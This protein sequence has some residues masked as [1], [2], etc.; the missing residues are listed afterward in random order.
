MLTCAIA[1]AFMLQASVH[2]FVLYHATGIF[3]GSLAVS[4]G[5]LIPL[6]CCYKSK[7]PMNYILL[8]FFTL[9]ESS[10]IGII[11]ANYQQAGYGILVLEAAGITAGIFVSLTV[12]TFWSKR[13]FSFLGMYLYAAL[14]G[15]LMWGLIAWLLGFDT[16]MLYSLL[17][18]FIFSGYIIYDTWRLKEKLGPD[19]YID[20][21]IELYLD[22]LNLFVYILDILGRSSR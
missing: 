10:L 1:Y 2:A 18:A 19:Q 22:I 7:Y 13:D 6:M 8:F 5:T 9:A 14:M 15:L 3:Y 16:G 21:A 12:Y 20:G 4:F 11:C 17:G